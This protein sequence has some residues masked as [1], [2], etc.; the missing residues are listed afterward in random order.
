MASATADPKVLTKVKSLTT[1]AINAAAIEHSKGQGGN[2][3]RST[4]TRA[5]YKIKAEALDQIAELLG[6]KAKPVAT[7]V[8]NGSGAAVRGS[9]STAKASARPRPK[10]TSAASSKKV[11]ASARKR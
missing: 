8:A 3:N 5:A 6:S 10:G 1:K 11:G 4:A 2:V 7:K 9:R